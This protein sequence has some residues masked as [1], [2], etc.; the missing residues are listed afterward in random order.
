LT[1]VPYAGM[2]R[3]PRHHSLHEGREEYL[4]AL[5]QARHKTTRACAVV[6]IRGDLYERLLW[7]IDDVA[8]KITGDREYLWI[9]DPSR[10]SSS[11]AE[12]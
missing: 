9:D 2:A 6:K 11:R 10:S 4:S 12:E 5:Y 8:E 3:S 7:A 1:L